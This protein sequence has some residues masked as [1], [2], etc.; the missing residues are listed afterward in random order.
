MHE[1]KKNMK[2]TVEFLKFT[3]KK[4]YKRDIKS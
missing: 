3:P 2:L 4:R 1:H